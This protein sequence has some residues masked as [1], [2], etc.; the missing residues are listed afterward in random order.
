ME[1]LGLQ[2]CETSS[3]PL[4]KPADTKRNCQEPQTSLCSVFQTLK[5]WFKM[6]HDLRQGMVNPNVYP[7][8]EIFCSQKRP[9]ASLSKVVFKRYFDR[10]SPDASIFK[11]TPI[12]NNS[13]AISSNGESVQPNRSSGS[14]AQC[15]YISLRH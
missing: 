2:V 8:F 15:F 5:Q 12:S 10:L 14:V 13:G 1:L 6:K 3:K 4:P 11:I 9:P 7:A